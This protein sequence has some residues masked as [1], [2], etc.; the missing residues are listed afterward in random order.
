MSDTELTDKRRIFRL[1]LLVM[2]LLLTPSLGLTQPKE[3]KVTWPVVVINRSI[4]KLDVVVSDENNEHKQLI[5]Q[6]M[7]A[8]QEIT[9]EASVKSGQRSLAW[10]VVALDDRGWKLKPGEK[11]PTRCGTGTASDRKTKLEVSSQN[12]VPGRDC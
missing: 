2:T 10:K 8:G 9:V 5:K 3:T 7:E 4:T 12:N 6:T 11:R 1:S